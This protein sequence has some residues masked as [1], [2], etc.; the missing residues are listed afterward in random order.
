MIE[1]NRPLVQMLSVMIL[2]G[3][4]IIIILPSTLLN[5]L[6]VVTLFKDKKLRTPLNLVIVHNYFCHNP[7]SN[8]VYGTFVGIPTVWSAL[9]FCDCTFRFF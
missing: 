1:V 6:I 3:Y 5:S 7:D 2:A 8:L 9:N 4:Y